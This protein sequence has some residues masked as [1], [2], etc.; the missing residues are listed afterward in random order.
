MRILFLDQ[1][2][3]WG[4]AQFALRDVMLEARKRGWDPHLMAPGHGPLAA[5]CESAGIGFRDLALSSYANGYKTPADMARF[6]LDLARSV[7]QVRSAVAEWRIDVIYANGPR[8]LPAC[9]GMGRPVLFHAHSYL[10]KTYARAIARACVSLTGAGVLA[11]SRF[12]ARPFAGRAITVYNGVPDCGWVPRRRPAGT[13]KIGIIGRIAPEKG[14]LDFLEAAGRLSHRDV[15]F[16][17]FG[18]AQFSD[19]AYERRLREKARGAR[20]ESPRVEFHGWTSDVATA[21]HGL[22]ILAVPSAPFEACPRIV[23][24]ALSAGTPVAAYPSGG[25]PEILT[26]RVTG[27]IAADRTSGDL[28]RSI[29]QFLDCPGLMEQCSHQGRRAWE[30]RFGLERFRKEAGDSIASFVE[31]PS[32]GAADKRN[33]GAEVAGATADKKDGLVCARTHSRRIH[34]E[35]PLPEDAHPASRILH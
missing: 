18:A 5:F 3:S 13:A 30:M 29:E 6:A 23:I 33:H 28:A 20:L 12:A 24:E 1:F 2:T 16:H 31:A 7:R 15:T 4:G 10:E 8:V 19:P 27:L 11:A 35:E 22:D 25:I 26:D 34:G 21:L 14:H 9:L 17:V 32:R